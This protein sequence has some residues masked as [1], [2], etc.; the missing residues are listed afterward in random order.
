M[1][2][3]KILAGL[4]AVL[5]AITL[6]SCAALHAQSP[7]QQEQTGKVLKAYLSRCLAV[8][9]PCAEQV[10]FPFYADG[11][12]L[13]R[14]AYLK[15]FPDD[16][17][18]A[19]V[20]DFELRH[21]LLPLEDVKIFWPQFWERLQAQPDFDRDKNRVYLAPFSAVFEKGKPEMGW[22]LL[23]YSNGNWRVAGLIDG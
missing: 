23:R 16:K 6:N 21:R 15:D 3:K 1:S 9:N 20:P 8:R 4:V 14:A 2:Q 22:L 18:D 12:A 17:T 5:G 10:S 19:E 7:E 11:K 13:D